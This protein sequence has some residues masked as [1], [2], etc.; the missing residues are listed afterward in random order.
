MSGAYTGPAKVRVLPPGASGID[1]LDSRPQGMKP[2]SQR[3]GS[4]MKTIVCS[5]CGQAGHNKKTCPKGTGGGG[6]AGEAR[7]A[8]EAL[9]GAVQRRAR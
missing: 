9:A 1:L 5:I 6:G 4:P 2:R 8:R 7:Q 3:E